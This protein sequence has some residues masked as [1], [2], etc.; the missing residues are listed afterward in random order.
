[1]KILLVAINAKYIHSNP[2]VY[3]LK[4]CTGEYERY[5]EIAEF[6]VNQQQSYILREIYQR[7]PD[8][9]A[10]SCY[11]WNR[12]IMDNIV[13]D[14]HKI[15][16]DADI[17]AG[18]P[19]VSYH[20]SESIEK[21]KLRG[22]MKGAGEGSFSY[23]VSAYVNG[24]SHSLPDILDG[25]NT[26]YLSLDEIPFWHKNMTDFEH[27]IIY[28]ESSRGCPFSCGY[29]LSSI[30]K[31]MDFRSVERVCRELDFFLE[32]KVTQIKFVDRTFNCKKEHALPILRHILAHDNGIT[33]F[34]FEMAADI[35]D[36]DYFAVLRCMRPG[37]VQLEIGVQSTC[38]NTIAEIH[39][40]MDFAKVADAVRR[41]SSW[42]NI[43]IHL[44]LIAGLPFE[45]L[46]TFQN[47]F[48]DV[49]GL[50][51]KQLQLGFLK[52]L[53]GSDM[54]RYASKYDLLYTDAPPYE[55]LSTKW[56]SYGDI[57][58]LKQVEEVLEIYYNSNQFMHTLE[59]LERY[60]ETPYD[61]YDALAAW[62]EEHDL[63]GPQSSRIRK[64]EILLEFGEHTLCA[65]ADKRK[66]EWKEY[67]IYDLYLREHMKSRPSFA[68]SG[69]RWKDGIHD[70]LHKESETH[71]LFPELSNCNYRELTKN[72]H[73]E[74]FEHIFEK[75]Q[76]VLF[77][78]ERRD[79]LT[80]NCMVCAVPISF[81][82][83]DNP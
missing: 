74:V 21:W 79:A 6:T 51:P 76:A 80:N 78:Y 69:E 62:Y 65:A 39:R 56:L 46:D 72:L 64:Y 40:K 77:C 38:E 19:E 57:C 26:P 54:A 30:E 45:D 9:I 52:V 17:W 3:S 42:N 50:R 16:P 8:V 47:S 7:N 82:R 71:E 59:F 33:N 70:I 5:V 37:A 43:H 32:R 81:V 13:P 31:N 14:L 15:L 66:A 68:D 24:F 23:L 34:H 12:Q 4:S 18:G 20:A 73:V 61:M 53:K 49:Y 27:R 29:C 60:F 83:T 10:F 22:V 41:I 44:D 25:S 58:H 36:E 63:F 48:N 1:M 55:V 75:R 35:L 2:A 28:Y 67:L 11:I